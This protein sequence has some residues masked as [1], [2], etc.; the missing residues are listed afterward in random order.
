MASAYEACLTEIKAASGLGD[1]TDDE[2]GEM[3]EAVLAAKNR[4]VRDRGVTAGDPF[5]VAAKE[6]ADQ[7][8]K[9]AAIARIDSLNSAAKRNAGIV[10]VKADSEGRI[11]HE[12]GLPVVGRVTRPI[13]VYAQREMDFADALEA[14]L[15]S[16]PRSRY[17]RDNV[18]SMSGD[19]ARRVRGRIEWELKQAG[20]WE[21]ALSGVL[22]DEARETRWRLKG[23]EPNPEI[24]VSAE[25]QKIGEVVHRWLEH[26]KDRQNAAAGRKVIG[27]APDYVH[28]TTW[29]PVSLRRAAGPRQSADAAFAGW[30]A[31]DMPRMAE[32]TFDGIIPDEGQSSL[33]AK[34][35]FL[36]SVYESRAT[37]IR[38]RQPQDP[39]SGYVPI[40]FEGTHN[41]GRELSHQRV[42]FWKTAQDHADH[43][44]E[45]GGGG[46]LLHTVMRSVDASA[47]NT[48][49]MDHFGLNPAGNLNLMIQS[50][51]R[52]FRGE[53]DAINRFNTRLA[54]VRNAMGRLDGT[55]NT[56]VNSDR[57]RLTDPF[58]T[59]MSA[60]AVSR[61]GF[62][63]VTHVFSALVTAPI[64]MMRHGVN[65]L[66]TMARVL[67]A[68]AKVLA[69]GRGSPEYQEV[70]ASVGAWTHSQVNSLQRHEP[71][72]GAGTP[73]FVSRSSAE[74]MRLT[75]LPRTIDHI[76][77]YAVKDVLLTLLGRDME[78]PLAAME[79]HRQEL[80]RSYGWDDK[81]WDL[82]RAVSDRVVVEGRT[83]A[84][85]DLAL[86]I[87]PAEIEAHLRATGVIAEKASAETIA[88]RVEDYQWNLADT[89]GSYYNDAADHA[90]VRPGVREQARVLGQAQP[91]T[92]DYMWRRALMQFK[93]W[94]LAEVTQI[95]G[96]LLATS[97]SRGEMWAGMG[98]LIAA[99]TLFGYGNIATRALLKGQPLPDPRDWKVALSAF[100]ASG[101]LGIFGDFLFGEISRMQ[102]GLVGTLGGPIAG[103]VDRLL[104][105]YGR[106]MTD[107]H[108]HPDRALNHLMPDI[109]R[110]TIDHIPFGNLVFLKGA[111][112]YMLWYH[113]FE[114]MSPGW[115][116]RTNQ[117]MLQKQGHAMVGYSPGAP[118]PYGVPPFYLGGSSPTGLLAAGR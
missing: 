95:V 107:I 115:W 102:E 71:W 33:E 40:A 20:V 67:Q 61:L 116:Q 10:R 21:Q 64:E 65:P 16:D 76:Q 4:I 2:A 57:F 94:P 30:V 47:R 114:T 91:G 32:K 73:G 62:V 100:A 63:D 85:P 83:Y 3:L 101:G 48:A 38:L 14:M 31:K 36:R 29:D 27:D 106:F 52:E 35:D 108:D 46:T 17:G 69:P 58:S 79:P 41:I 97:M 59:L 12:A 55:L 8:K 88:R 118:V 93:M 51:Q 109:L 117:R 28:E 23:G 22:D 66:E 82:Y 50:L 1:M 113:L 80:L 60:E 81:A 72:T 39:D 43:Q 13:R 6:A 89:L 25:G 5:A 103:D 53:V 87:D 96:K 75:G 49:L 37:G 90:I 15:D 99:G 68:E 74:F 98:W 84:T 24:K 77:W 44:R 54:H 86:K 92:L 26:M 56:P 19:L 110:Q 34:A 105:T 9:A 104:R 42:I 78:K 70:A 7:L 18:D 111:L 45:F 112:D 11:A